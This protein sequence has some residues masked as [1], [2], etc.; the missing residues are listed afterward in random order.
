MGWV[1]N[2]IKHKTSS[3][4]SVRLD[5]RRTAVESSNL[6]EIGKFNQLKARKKRIRFARSNIHEWGLFALEPIEQHDMVIEYIGEVIRQKVA[7][8]R[9]KRYEKMGIGSSY[10][11]RIDEG[12][13]RVINE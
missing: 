8:I 13:S 2:Q 11:F 4:R 3:Q 9:E 1:T 7:D 10:L 5:H 12:Q 6:G